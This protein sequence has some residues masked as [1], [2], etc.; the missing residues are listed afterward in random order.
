MGG[1]GSEELKKCPPPF[2][3]VLRFVNVCVKKK[4]T[5]NFF[6]SIFRNKK[7]KTR[8]SILVSKIW[9][10]KAKL[11]LNY[12]RVGKKVLAKVNEKKK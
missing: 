11:K 4:K 10:Q 8:Q 5:E 7:G 6:K 3:A 2:P 9:Q 12:F 1:S